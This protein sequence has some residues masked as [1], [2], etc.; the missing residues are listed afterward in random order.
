M[1]LSYQGTFVPR[2]VP[3]ILL[4]QA[5]SARGN[6]SSRERR[7]LGTKVPGNESSK[8]R[9]FHLWN[10]CS[11][12]RKFLG[13]K[14][15]VTVVR[16]P[17]RYIYG[18]DWQTVKLWADWLCVMDPILY[19]TV[20]SLVL[21]R[22]HRTQVRV[23]YS[24]ATGNGTHSLTGSLDRRRVVIPF[25]RLHDHWPCPKQHLQSARRRPPAGW[26]DAGMSR[27]TSWTLPV[28]PVTGSV[29]CMGVDCQMKCFMCRNWFL[30][31]TC[32]Y[33]YRDISVADSAADASPNFNYS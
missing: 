23:V 14:V 25:S 10:F 24:M 30:Q 22:V 5:I 16:T 8:E 11:W 9:K 6:E 7:F 20:R 29:T 1:E 4:S 33:K 26:P 21:S 28:R 12:E 27:T 17:L 15:P 19:D 31:T 13:T 32:M 2:K 18:S 3:S